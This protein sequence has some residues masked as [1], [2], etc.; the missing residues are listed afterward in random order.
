MREP[1][2]VLLVSAG[3]INLLPGEMNDALTLPFMLDVFH[4]HHRRNRQQGLV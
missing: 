4:V 1:L 2:F 3:T